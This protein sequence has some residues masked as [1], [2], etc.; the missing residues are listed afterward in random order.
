MSKYRIP[1]IEQSEHS[2]C[3]LCSIAMILSYYR[4]EYSI[5]ELRREWNIGRDGT[6]LLILKRIATVLNFHTTSFRIG[7]IEELPEPCILHINNNHFVVLEKVTKKGVYLVDPSRGRRRIT[8][9]EFRKSNIKLGLYI[10]PSEKVV[11]RKTKSK[12]SSYKNLLISEYKWF[13]LIIISTLLLQLTTL[14]VPMSIEYITDNIVNNKNETYLSLFIILIVS[15]V[16]LNWLMNFLKSRTAVLLQANVDK[17]L[18]QT[19]VNKLLSLPFNYFES[20]HSGDLIQ[21]YSSNIIIRELLSNRMITIFLDGGLIVIFFIYMWTLSL[22]LALFT[23]VL[24]LLQVIIV[25]ISMRK[26]KTLQEKEVMEQV[27]ASNY[28]AE[29]SK[30]AGIIKTKGIENSVYN[31]WVNLFNKQVQAMKKRGYFSSSINSLNQSI[32]FAAPLVLILLA[33]LEVMKGKLTVGEMFSFYII[34]INFL[35]PITSIIRAINEL[36]YTNV[37]FNRV[38]DVL[39]SESERNINSGVTSSE[40]AGNIEFKEVSY[41][42]GLHSKE[43]LKEL[44]LNIKH[45]EFVAVVGE[46]GSGKSTLALLLLGLSEP[47]KGEIYFNQ[48]NIKNINKSEFRKK[49]G[50]VRQDITIFNQSIKE[51]I[52]LGLSNI[53]D[54]QVITASK[55]AE[56]YTEI[57]QMP[58]G[59]ET[60]LSEQGG[61]ISGGQRQRIALAR[62]LLSKPSILLL[63]EAT[64]S[65]DYNT[66]EKIQKNLAELKCTRI[67]IAHRLNTI[68]KADKI[69]VLKDGIVEGNGNHQELINTCSYYKDLYYKN[70]MNGEM[71]NQTS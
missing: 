22:K 52:V 45:G 25:S 33:A 4:C 40:L 10:Y 63:D 62:A 8:K 6:S 3:G 39:E 61:N 41:N 20:R 65:L 16:F 36:I 49:I 56:I 31:K 53:S 18:M 24:G 64:S 7:V 12:I 34:S 29:I 60:I 44:N 70:V 17:K 54:E 46:S 26:N 13:F 51:N 66:E 48:I 57:I 1:F 28:F 42:Y 37:Y 27:N 59:F 23:T 58:M 19:F 2:E 15:V 21:R 71:S 47:T 9:E 32:Q 14:S 11:K 35:T 67:V 5:I 50:V 30:S 68:I 55:N 69:I 38:L 43:V